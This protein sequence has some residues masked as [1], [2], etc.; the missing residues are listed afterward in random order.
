[1]ATE[2]D[3]AQ[4]VL[5]FLSTENPGGGGGGSET[6]VAQ[7]VVEVLYIAGGSTIGTRVA[8]SVIEFLSTDN[9]GGG[10][11]AETRVAQS[12]IEVLYCTPILVQC[13]PLGFQ[14]DA[15]CSPPGN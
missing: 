13:F 10:G 12:V 2:T 9:P 1:M 7:S 15:C 14:S 5:E 3:V 11:T 6:Q 8:Q 4:S